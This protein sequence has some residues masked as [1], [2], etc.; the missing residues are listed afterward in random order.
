MLFNSLHFLIFFPLVC[1]LYFALPQRWRWAL[2][3]AAS[4][5]FYMSWRAEYLPLLLLS[6]LIDYWAGLKMGAM[7]GQAR[8]KR[9]LV[10]S[11]AANLAILF[12]FKYFNFF[13]A[14]IRT[15]FG[16]L[17][18]EYA[19]PAV[20]LLLP[21][22]IS[23]Y[24]FHAMSYTIDVYRGLKQPETHVG[25]FL[26]YILF[27]PQLVAGPISRPRQLLPQFHLPHD[28]DPARV[29][30]GLA[31]M[32]WGFFKKLVIADRL[33]LVVNNVYNNPTDYTGVALIIA[34]YSFA[35]QIYCDFSGYSDIA[36]GAAR[37]LGYDL[38]ENFRRPYAATSVAD[39][40]SRWHISLST[41]FRDYLYVPL[42][43][44]RVPRPRWYFNLM[45]VFLVSGLWHGANWTFVVWGALH[46][47]YVL[48]EIWTRGLRDRL[49]QRLGLARRPGWL[50]A[51][52]WLLTFHLVTFAWIF[53]RASTL[54]DALYIAGH[55]LQGWSLQAG[56]GLGVGGYELVIAGGALA[57]LE[58]VQWLQARGVTRPD[59][60][61][62]PAWLR[63]AGYYALGL[64]ILLFG[65]FGATEFIY[66]QF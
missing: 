55:L 57:L 3:L 56:Y 42:G 43:G 35:F 15:L 62:R 30:S 19:V 27:F 46:G 18:L 1:A 38:M 41:W 2:L 25:R 24:T 37:I 61:A 8:R 11:L 33:A 66:F 63:W 47:L 10:L 39:F 23:F 36:L 7:P 32:A 45:F 12:V 53:F 13:N 28:F 29:T 64:L 40:W 59:F 44:N 54:N 21:V 6:T 52:S 34:T 20:N 4:V 5:Y 31:L 14:S 65:K 58:L 51:L 49:L 50:A 60:A 16:A 22:G 48:V 17:G 9:Y 26:L